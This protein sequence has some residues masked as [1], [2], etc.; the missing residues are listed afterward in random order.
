MI[1]RKNPI[2]ICSILA[3]TLTAAVAALGQESAALK[4]VSDELQTDPYNPILVMQQ[5]MLARKF[6]EEVTEVQDWRWRRFQSNLRRELIGPQDLVDQPGSISRSAAVLTGQRAIEESLQ[7][8]SIGVNRD[9]ADSSGATPISEIG[10]VEIA[11]HPWEEMIGGQ[12]IAIPAIARLVPNDMLFVHMRHP[13]Q[14]LEFEQLV[15]QQSEIFGDVYGLGAAA[16]LKEKIM[17]R[18]GVPDADAFVAA[19]EQMAFISD[20]LSF[21]PGTDYA[22]ILKPV[23]AIAEK[24]FELLVSDAAIYRKVGDYLVVATHTEIINRVQNASNDAA[25]AMAGELDYQY[26][27]ANMEPL[28]DGLIYLSESFIRKLTGPAYRINARRRNTVLA[29]LETLQYSVFAYRRITGQWPASIQQMVDEKY[30]EPG[31]VFAQAA[32]S[33]DGDGRVSHSTW[34]SLWNVNPVNRVPIK[35]ASNGERDNYQRFSGG[36][37]SF[38]REFFDPIGIAYTVSDQLYLHT[39]ILPLIDNSDYRELSSY[40][41]GDKRPLEFI[42]DSER[43]GA[44]NM[45][46]KFSIDNFLLQFAR[47]RQIEEVEGETPEAR[48]LRVVLAVESDISKEVFGEP[49]ADG[50]RLL[51]FIGDEVVFGVGEDNSFS[52][53]NIADLDIWFGL[54]LDDRERAEAFFRKLW[55]RIVGEFS[56]RQAG[57]FQLS[58]SE[59]LS[60]EYN[61]Q[62]FFMLPTGYVNVYYIFFDDAFYVTVS[63]LAMNRLI[64]AHL[65]KDKATLLAEIERGFANIGAAHDIV[66]AL[67]F[68]RI[69][70]FKLGKEMNFWGR[71]L[72]QQFNVLRGSLNEGLTLAKILPDYAGSLSNTSSYFSALPT[73]FYGAD[74]KAR[75]GELFLAAGQLKEP[76]SA[77]GSGSFNQ[78]LDAILRQSMPP[79]V[80]RRQ[81]SQF[82]SGVLGVAFLPEGLEVKIAIGNPNVTTP[83]ER[84][85]FSAIGDDSSATPGNTMLWVL[86]G[87][88]AFIIVLF[89]LMRTRKNN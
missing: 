46:A 43:L 73:S 86:L 88:G 55:Q 80:F 28:R 67:D 44:I 40:F 27:L 35:T 66:A 81:L 22:L 51:D 61:G 2:L 15:E 79:E 36:Y 26:T 11:S 23:N 69:S 10:P 49:L 34:G 75:D 37:Q 62:Q 68:S 16:T 74:I 83:D 59:P 78:K 7:L 87:I 41:N 24:G 19:F 32:Y 63:Q 84:F 60:N 4:S 18:L 65:D 29:A 14:F 25:L 85:S 76:F 8:G 72:P 50:E 57:F 21:K 64:D 58:S 33:I 82:R 12:T 30:L 54:K 5:N 45:A 89:V 3:A 52:M 70:T 20:D 39:L 56:G 1:T 53:N 48:R 6:G 71:T 77:L 38:F 47:S 9:T 42:F 31:K 13:A 17:Q